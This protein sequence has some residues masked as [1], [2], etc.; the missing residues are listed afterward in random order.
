MREQ[1]Q[2]PNRMP[3][4]IKGGGLE[5]IREA[6]ALSNRESIDRTRQQFDRIRSGEFI[7]GSADEKMGNYKLTA[8][9]AAGGSMGGQIVRSPARTAPYVSVCIN[10]K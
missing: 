2:G 6:L 8:V 4:D 1:M 3:L 7:L 10:T 5:G 9:A